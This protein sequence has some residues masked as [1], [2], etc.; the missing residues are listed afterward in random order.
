MFKYLPSVPEWTSKNVR[1]LTKKIGVDGT[2]LFEDVE[3]WKRNPVNI[4]Q[5]LLENPDFRNEIRYKPTKLYTD[6][7]QTERIYNEMW[8]GDWWNAT[9]VSKLHIRQNNEEL[10]DIS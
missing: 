9:A 6:E 7:E 10:I 2:R 8:T 3:L 4:I 1:I 5:E